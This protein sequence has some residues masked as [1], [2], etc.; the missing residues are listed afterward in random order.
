MAKT[1]RLTSPIGVIASAMLTEAQFQALNGASW[2]LADGRSVD[3][4][5]YAVMTGQT[6]VPDLR[7]MVLRG[8][9]NGRS[10]GRENPS[11]VLK[12]DLTLGSFL[13]NDLDSQFIEDI[14]IG[15]KVSG[16]GL[17][18]NAK[19]V[20]KDVEARS[21]TLNLAAISTQGDVTLT[22]E[23]EYSLGEFQADRFKS[24]Q[25]EDRY[26]DNTGEYHE[27]AGG[28]LTHQVDQ[29][30]QSGATGG[31]ETRM[32]NVTVNFFIKINP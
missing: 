27:Q 29:Y 15:A 10:D 1:P 6:S 7:G 19:V 17:P 28:W 4:S 21:V 25:H 30:R 32:K 2:I 23:S 24:H 31:N 16:V 11:V 18:P 8:K 3:G 12:G 5:S 20:A 9:N 26:Q 22:F 13:I 14:R